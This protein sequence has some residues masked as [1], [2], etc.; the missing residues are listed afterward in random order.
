MSPETAV[1]GIE[2]ARI[3]KHRISAPIAV[4]R[5]DDPLVAVAVA[6]DDRSNGRRIDAGHV[7]G[8]KEDSV[9]IGVARGASAESNRAALSAVVVAVIDRVV[10]KRRHHGTN[11]I[12]VVADDA[13]HVLE[14]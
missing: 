4:G 8:K 2:V 14:R 10:H 1:R 6:V 12:G 7:A 9:R 3:E 11:A 5:R 13:D